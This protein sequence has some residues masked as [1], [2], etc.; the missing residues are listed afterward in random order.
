MYR[1]G[2]VLHMFGGRT[3]EVLNTDAEGRL[4]LADAIAYADA[5]AAHLS[6]LAASIYGQFDRA[7]EELAAADEFDIT[8]VNTSVQDVCRQLITLM[9]QCGSS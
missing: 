6:A 3:V 9:E 5:A 8:L 4:V 7:R 1:P 2:D